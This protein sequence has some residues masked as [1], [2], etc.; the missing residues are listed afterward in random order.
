MLST[1]IVATRQGWSAGPGLPPATA[2]RTAVYVLA[3]VTVLPYS[4]R[5]DRE[6]CAGFSPVAFPSPDRPSR[7]AMETPP[8]PAVAQRSTHRFMHTGPGT[9]FPGIP[10]GNT[11]PQ[12]S[13]A[14]CR[15]QEG[16]V[17]GGAEAARCVRDRRFPALDFPRSKANAGSIRRPFTTRAGIPRLPCQGASEPVGRCR[18]PDSAQR[19]ATEGRKPGSASPCLGRISAAMAVTALATGLPMPPREGTG[20]QIP[21]PGHRHG[22]SCCRPPK[23]GAPRRK[24]ASSGRTSR[25]ART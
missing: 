25:R 17:S 21:E 4:V 10:A 16:T 15:M 9:S 11:K 8:L 6:T 1:G 19:H 22:F 20:Q 18:A 2:S 13:S 5:L 23:S 12:R 14:Q 7:A 24:V 3:N